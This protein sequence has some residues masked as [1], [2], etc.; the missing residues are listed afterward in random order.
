MKS[1]DNTTG[2]VLLVDDEE[3]GLQAG[4]QMLKALGYKVLVA[5][6]GDEAIQLCQENKERI[7]LTILDVTMPGM[8][9]VDVC[10]KLKEVKPDM[11]I[12]LSSGYTLQYLTET[13]AVQG[14]DVFLEKPFGIDMLSEKLKEILD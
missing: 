3:M 6:C 2:T 5:R 12:I 8:S 7:G 11:K 9:G 1:G 4:E 10:R 14:Y 13:T